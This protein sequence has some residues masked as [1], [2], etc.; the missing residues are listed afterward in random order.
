MRDRSIGIGFP[1]RVIF[2]PF[3]TVARRRRPPSHTPRRTTAPRST[4][5]PNPRTHLEPLPS[6]YVFCGP[7]NAPRPRTRHLARSGPSTYVLLGPADNRYPCSQCTLE[8]LLLVLRVGD[9]PRSHCNIFFPITGN[10]AEDFRPTIFGPQHTVAE[11]PK[12]WLSFYSLSAEV[13]FH[14]SVHR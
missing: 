11:H 1:R 10:I 14:K 5:P 12:Y 8:C 7:S 6:G 3:C 2:H 4:L 9:S 13:S